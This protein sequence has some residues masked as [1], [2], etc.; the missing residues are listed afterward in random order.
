MASI[1]ID[2]GSS[3]S[4]VSW[5]NPHSGKPEAVKFN[6][7]GS[8]KMPSI[9]FASQDGFHYGFQAQD[10]LD[11]ISVLPFSKRME[12]LPNFIP[13]LKRILNPNEQEWFY[14][15]TY[16][17]NELLLS[18]LRHLI[19]QAQLHCGNQ[20]EIDEV[21]ISHPV[22]FSKS[23]IE[24]LKSTLKQLG[25][26]KVNTQFEPVSAVKGYGLEHDILDKEGVLVF[27]FGG[28]TID[29]AF[30]QK[31]FGKL[32][33][34][35]EPKGNSHCG[36]QDVDL[37]L[38]ENLRKIIKSERGYDISSNGSI[39]QIALSSCRKLK[40]K[41]S[42]ENDAYETVILLPIN[43][44]LDSYKY[45][46]SR[47]SFNS[48]ILPIL[49]D[50]IDIADNVIKDVKNKGLHITRTLLIGGSSQLSLIRELLPAHLDSDTELETCG[51]KDIVVALGNIADSF[52]GESV[53][54]SS[55][56]QLT[57][58]PKVQCKYPSKAPLDY[59]RS[60]KC[61]KCNS[62]HCYHFAEKPGYHCEDCGW[63][64][65]NVIIK[66]EF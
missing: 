47:E 63:E 18:F 29:V 64:G 19:S 27:D 38:Y 35:T 16:T 51:E 14:G 52:L 2:F 54:K 57:I 66:R 31:R 3:Y 5:I 58:K 7:D 22:D 37:A 10:Y 32:V 23:K 45:R 8:V 41:F 34:A 60:I 17:H 12:Y 43:G 62:L 65:A 30:I 21:I 56:Q 25:Y 33:V 40:E 53:E 24:L 15:K 20:Y 46:L 28:G 59:N 55:K 42:G 1:G 11:E 13:S 61:L 50:A 36:G 48:L 26:S 39:D 6:G 44:R 49:S 9:I 4:T